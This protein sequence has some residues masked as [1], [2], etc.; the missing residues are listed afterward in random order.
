[1]DDGARSQSFTMQVTELVRA[2]EQVTK[3]IN[4]AD[5]P[6]ETIQRSWNRMN[7]EHNT[8]GTDQ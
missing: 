1:M 3:A 5:D 7:N 6:S 8:I 2:R 4:D